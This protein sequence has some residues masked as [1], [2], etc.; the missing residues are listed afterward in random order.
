MSINVEKLEKL[1]EE[2]KVVNLR[3]NESFL[4][5]QR[6]LKQLEMLQ[7]QINVELGFSGYRL[8]GEVFLTP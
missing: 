5:Q 2:Y 8:P 1:I 3:K 4:E 6:I 7:A